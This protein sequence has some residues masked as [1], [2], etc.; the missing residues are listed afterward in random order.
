M[1]NKLSVFKLELEEVKNPAIRKFAEKVISNIPDYFFE[2]AAS[3]TGKYHPIYAL[4]DGGLVRHTKAAVGIAI[5]LLSLEH[6]IKIYS[7]DERDC[8]IVALICHDGWK[9][10]DTYNKYTVANHPVVAAENII[11]LADKNEMEFA[12]A[13]A[14]N[15]ISHMGQWNT[16]YK[17]KK[18]IMPKPTTNSQMFVHTCD[19]LASRKYLTYEFSDYYQPSNFVE[20]EKSEIEKRIS[21]LV[22]LCKNKISEGVDRNEL[23]RIISENNDGK[24]N[25]NTIT[26]ISVVNKII[27]IIEETKG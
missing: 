9:H 6:N 3:S 17:S 11:L 25:P 23:Y 14:D 19:Y 15:I 26:D 10:G 2:T 5:D 1:Y 13:I 4:G 20:K 22:A 18:E 21:E 8:I 27:G 24:K 7:P 12:K 16:D